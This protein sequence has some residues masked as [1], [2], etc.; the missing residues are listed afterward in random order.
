MADSPTILSAKSVFLF[1]NSVFLFERA[2]LVLA[3]IK[4]PPVLILFYIPYFVI[5]RALL[6]VSISFYT[7]S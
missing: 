5:S 4:L 3:T 1:V 6:S 7:F 2:L